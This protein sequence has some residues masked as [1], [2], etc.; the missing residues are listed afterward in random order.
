MRRQLGFTLVELVTVII[1]LGILVVGVSSFIIFGTRIFMDSSAAD[2]IIGSSRFVMSRLTREL[3]NAV[4]GSVR[5][6]DSGNLQCVEFLPVSVSGSYLSLPMAPDSMADRMQVFT[7]QTALQSGMQLLVY[8]LST[9]DVYTVANHKRFNI[10]NASTTGATTEIVFDSSVAFAEAS[11]GRRWYAAWQPVSYC[12]FASGQ[13][14]RYGNYGY[15][16]SQP[17]PPAVTG[18]LMA[19]DLSNDFVAELPLALT[20]PS[21]TNNAIVQLRPRFSILGES[22][23]YQH[24]V[25]VF[26]VP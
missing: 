22:F 18:V 6:A 11:P 8:P 24:Q 20:P 17:L 7:P 3:Q 25:Q 12:F 2:R 9:A 1:I 16:A 13:I 5:L 26:N 10:K 21:L 4:P 23:T 19:E 15:Q 14:R